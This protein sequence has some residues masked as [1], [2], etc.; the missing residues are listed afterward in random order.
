METCRVFVSLKKEMIRRVLCQALL[1]EEDS[2]IV[3]E[4]RNNEEAFQE[5]LEI[6][7]DIAILDLTDEAMSGLNASCIIRKR[8]P[9]VSVI[10]TTED[11]NHQKV[12]D[13]MKSGA[14][15]YFTHNTTIEEIRRVV[16]SIA[17]GGQPI[18]SEVV[19][20]DIAI[21]LLRQFENWSKLDMLPE[22]LL[23]ELLPAETELLLGISGRNYQ[24]YSFSS[25]V[26]IEKQLM[27]IVRK[28]VYNTDTIE[29][30]N[31][32]RQYVA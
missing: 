31:K 16:R 18:T 17:Q 21:N 29:T 8:L 4:S 24:I 9:I 12:I 2:G 28:L 26:I 27:S 6:V 13:I 10:L 23:A 22:G 7:P 1:D 25:R 3:S 20:P 11:I 32:Y 30:I 14:S 19:E 15:A 5:I